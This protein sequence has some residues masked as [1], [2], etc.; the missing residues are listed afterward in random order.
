MVKGQIFRR[1][2]RPTIYTPEPVPAEDPYPAL[3][4]VALHIRYYTIPPRRFGLRLYSRMSSEEALD[5]RLLRL[6]RA[7]A[8]RTPRAVG[9]S[10]QGEA[11]VALLVRPREGLEL[12]LIRRAE[13]RGDPWSG[14]VALPGGRRAPHDPDLLTTAARETEEEVG[15]PLHATGRLIGPLDELSPATPLL[16]PLVIAPFVMAVPPETTSRPD[17]REVQSALWVPVDALRQA[18]ARSST[19][20]ELPTGRRDFPCLVYQDFVIWG[21]T[22]RILEQFLAIVE[23]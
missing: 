14:H 10:G 1:E 22:Y 23:G 13:L 3:A 7:L 5:P 12:L 11:A 21:L 16:P 9:R 15:V 18:G 19:T 17:G 2:F 20:I 8:R 6:R 4:S